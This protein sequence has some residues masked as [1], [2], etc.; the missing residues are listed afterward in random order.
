MKVQK[1][2][3]VPELGYPNRRQFSECKVL[4]GAAVI[5]LGGIA[6]AGEPPVRLDGDI[7]VAPR[8]EAP[9]KPAPAPA[10]KPK[11]A[12]PVMAPEPQIA[13]GGVM[14]AP[15]PP[16]PPKPPTPPAK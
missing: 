1:F 2:E 4:L 11:P 13:V 15:K 12:K 9:A 10:E 14:V 7:M 3:Q 5:G 6:I 16:E 8:I